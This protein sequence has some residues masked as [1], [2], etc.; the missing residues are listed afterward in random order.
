[1]IVG[2]GEEVEP[3]TDQRIEPSRVASEIVGRCL[4]FHFRFQIVSVR[5][6]GLEI[7]EGQIAVHLSGDAAQALCI[8]EALPVFGEARG[9]DGCVLRVETSVAGEQ[10]RE[11]RWSPAA[12]GTCRGLCAA[13]RG[14]IFGWR[15]S[16]DRH[17]GARLTRKSDA[18]H[19]HGCGVDSK[20][21]PPLDPH[22]VVSSSA[23]AR[24]GSTSNPKLWSRAK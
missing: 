20:A 10:Q 19:E 12:F 23:R 11:L 5:H 9:T 3:C 18:R 17:L 8:G 4:P 24:I 14:S 21:H 16:A 2:Q 22:A 15:A 13:N 1:M 6:H 7:E